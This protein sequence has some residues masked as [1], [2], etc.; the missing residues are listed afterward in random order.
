[1]TPEKL[2]QIA[3]SY[4]YEQLVEVFKYLQDEIADVRKGN[5]SLEARKESIEIMEEFL[6]KLRAMKISE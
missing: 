6:K 3:N 1:M 4:T 2:K 5:Y